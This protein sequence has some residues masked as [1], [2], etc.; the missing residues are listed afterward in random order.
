MIARSII[1]GLLTFFLMPVAASG[2]QTTTDQGTERTQADSKN[3]NPAA[4]DTQDDASAIVTLQTHDNKIDVKVDGELFTTF[5][6][7]SYDKP[8]LYPI[9]SPGQ[10]AMTRDWPMKQDTKGESHDHPHHKSMWIAHEINGVDF[11]AEKGGSVKTQSV[12]S[13]FVGEPSNVFRANSNWVKKSDGKTLLS[14]Q[15]TYWFGGDKTSRW[16]NC[17]VKYQATHGDFQFDDTKEGLFAIR[18]HPNLRLTSKPKAGV[19][20]VFGKAINSEGVT[21]KEIWGKRAKWLLYYGE[22]DGTPVSIAMYD[23]PSNL[24]HP[25]TWHARDYGLV[26]AN[27]FGLHHFLGREKGSGAFKV[28]NG[29]ALQLRYRVEFFKGIATVETIDEKFQA[30]AKETL[31]EVVANKRK[32]Q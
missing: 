28:K 8:I 31:A 15:S 10:I 12:E 17:L 23:H 22:I 24:R 11:W 27:P 32:S 2:L 26:T 7:A 9:Y 14:D 4:I 16:I 20:E 1:I 29:G 21:G 6:Y 13:N 5:D 3:T 30:F 18:T 19:T 25:T